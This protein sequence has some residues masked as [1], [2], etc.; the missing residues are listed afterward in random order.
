MQEKFR[1]LF[2]FIGKTGFEPATPYSQ[3]KCANRAALLPYLS[4][5]SYHSLR[6]TER[7]EPCD[8]SG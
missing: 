3:S 8:Y 6:T 7:G 2:D 1:F 5:L 4:V